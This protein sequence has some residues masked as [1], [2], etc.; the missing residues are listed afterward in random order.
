VPIHSCKYLVELFPPPPHPPHE[1]QKP[2]E[3]GTGEKGRAEE[4]E[5]AILR[6]Q[7]WVDD[8]LHELGEARC[9]CC[10]CGGRGGG[11]LV[12]FVCGVDGWVGG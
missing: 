4:E 3:G 12:V 10:V 9:V 8:R 5:A 2:Q 1:H 6:N 7:R 11:G